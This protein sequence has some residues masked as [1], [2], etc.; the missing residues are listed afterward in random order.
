MTSKGFEVSLRIVDAFIG[1]PAGSKIKM[2][3]FAAL[4]LISTFLDPHGPPS[5][6][7]YEVLLYIIVFYGI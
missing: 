5:V 1:D 4:V 6:H 3:R 2:T 7:R